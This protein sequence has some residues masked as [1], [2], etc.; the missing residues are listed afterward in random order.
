MSLGYITTKDSLIL[1]KSKII[2]KIISLE[3]WKQQCIWLI[4]PIHSTLDSTGHNTFCVES[5][6]TSARQKHIHVYDGYL[7]PSPS[8]NENN[9]VSVEFYPR[10][11]QVTLSAPT[12]NIKP[13]FWSR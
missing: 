5:T 3:I 7:P 9:T 8:W 4:H 1:I 2:P 10:F 11:S 6:T 12:S 13:V